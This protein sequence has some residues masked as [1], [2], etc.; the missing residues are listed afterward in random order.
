[1]ISAIKHWPD[2]MI[3]STIYTRENF[4]TSILN[5][6]HG[7]NK[8]ASFA[9]NKFSRFKPNLEMTIVF[10]LVLIKLFFYFFTKQWNICSFFARFVRHFKS[11]TKIDHFEIREMLCYFEQNFNALGKNFHI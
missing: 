7:C 2:Q 8:I 1:M 3:E 6:I 11:S 5:N 10:F 4:V 9:Y